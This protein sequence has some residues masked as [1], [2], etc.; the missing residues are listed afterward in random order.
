[1]TVHPKVA[2]GAGGGA[3]GIVVTWVAGQAGLAMT[4]E[5]AAAVAFT[6]AALFGW[7]KGA[8]KDAA[9]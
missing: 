7:A 5:V 1:M 2:A 4:P 8:G 6:L 9:R 3:L